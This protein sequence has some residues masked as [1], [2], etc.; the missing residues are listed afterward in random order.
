MTFVKA[1]GLSLFV[2]A[3]AAMGVVLVVVVP[4]WYGAEQ[5]ATPR[6]A[7]ATVERRI[8]A[9]LLF[10]SEDGERLVAYEREIPYGDGV[11]EQAKRIIE[12][13]AA[14]PPAPL[15]SALPKGTKVRS[16]FVTKDGA[17]YVDLSRE[18]SASHPGGSLNE[19]LT[20]YAVVDGLTANLPAITSVQILVDGREVD[21]LA[22]HVDLRRPLVKSKRWIK[23]E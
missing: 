20:V 5:Q 19:I 14:N 18:V 17:A 23:E 10:V 1:L 15:A 11:V 21:T 4:R 2:V 7:T 3:V 16:V 8:K 6:E 22:G 13:E 9:T 12:A